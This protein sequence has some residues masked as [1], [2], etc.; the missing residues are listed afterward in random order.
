MNSRTTAQA[1]TSAWPDVWT[2]GLQRKCAGCGT[3]TVAGGGCSEC[4]KKRDLLQGKAATSEDV[5]E[6]PQSVHQVLRSPGQP[7]DSATRA[8]MEPRFGHDFSGVRVHAD[9][10]AA[11]SARAVNAHAYTVG[12]DVVFGRGQFAPHTSAGRQ[13]LAHELTHVVQQSQSSTNQPLAV[14][15]ANDAYDQAADR[16]A[17]S[18]MSREGHVGLA[19]TQSRRWEFHR[20]P[21]RHDRRSVDRFARLRTKPALRDRSFHE[22]L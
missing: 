12:K 20:S 4:S 22:A 16:A 1:R 14:G 8:Y 10:G 7:L 6:V 9:A 15:P 21:P 13:L 11:E 2:C 5:N 3:H 18:V 17:D 19:R